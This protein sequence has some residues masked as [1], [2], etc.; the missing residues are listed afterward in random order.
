MTLQAGGAESPA[1]V[2]IARCFLKRA[3]LCEGVV[4]REWEVEGWGWKKHYCLDK[5]LVGLLIVVEARPLTAWRGGGG[6]DRE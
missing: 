6:A 4:R 1:I 5:F 2:V 3:L